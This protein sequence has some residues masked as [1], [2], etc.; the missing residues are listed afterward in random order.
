MVANP[1]PSRRTTDDWSPNQLA[2]RDAIVQA[3]ARLMIREGVRACTSRAISATS[4]MSTS[5]LHYYFRDTDEILDLAFRRIGERFFRR[6]EEVARSE[7]K[8]VDALWGAAAVYLE[9]GSEWHEDESKAERGAPMLWFEFQAESLRSGD[10]TT[11]R[12]LSAMGLTI[13]ERLI[14]A[15][16]IAPVAAAAQ[17]LYSALLGAAIRDSLF[18]RPNYEVLA[19]LSAMLG[20]PAS[21]KYCR[22]PR[23]AKPRKS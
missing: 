15:A 17:T 10:L 2:K 11:A 6:L 1:I 7:P 20:L 9:R 4:E 22:A 21:A 14:K 18:H 16:G 12:E 13:F 3:T 8:P 5:A 23:T 19:E